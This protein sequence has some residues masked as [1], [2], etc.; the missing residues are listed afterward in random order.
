MFV[1]SR[2]SPRG[3][4]GRVQGPGR[5]ELCAASKVAKIGRAVRQV[6]SLP[7][8]CVQTPAS[9]PL[10][11]SHLGTSADHHCH[12]LFPWPA[13]HWHWGSPKLRPWCLLYVADLTCVYIST[14]AD[15]S[16]AR[17]VLVR[18]FC[19]ACWIIPLGWENKM[20]SVR[21]ANVCKRFGDRATVHPWAF[22]RV[23]TFG[24]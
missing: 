13:P 19:T 18:M 24:D 16:Q 11:C 15:K 3:F 22:L 12:C 17:R 2:Y 14:Q 9:A 6:R 20:N 8:G 23:R 4:N 7:R 10:M 1:R 21:F 5:S